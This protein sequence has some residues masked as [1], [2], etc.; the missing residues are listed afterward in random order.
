MKIICKDNFDSETKDDVLICENVGKY[1]GTLIVSWLNE[2][3]S[4]EHSSL[5]FK[6][7]EDDYQLYKFQP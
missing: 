6:L 7:V 2:K 1:Y 4:G 5:F 3:L